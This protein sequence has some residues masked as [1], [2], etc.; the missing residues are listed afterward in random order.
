MANTLLPRLV[1]RPES[2]SCQ[3]TY[4]YPEYHCTRGALSGCS[5]RRSSRRKFVAVGIFFCFSC[6]CARAARQA[7]SGGHAPRKPQRGGRAGRCAIFRCE[8]IYAAW[9]VATETSCAYGTSEPCQLRSHTILEIKETGSC[10]I[11]LKG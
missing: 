5:P 7:G 10:A 9:L 3:A 11:P 8:V 2:D 4:L 1:C 6:S